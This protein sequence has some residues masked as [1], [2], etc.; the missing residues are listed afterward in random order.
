S[1][2]GSDAETLRGLGLAKLELGDFSSSLESLQRAVHVDPRDVLS[3][4]AMARL[5]NAM[6]SSGMGAAHPGF[7]ARE[8]SENCTKLDPHLADAYRQASIA[9]MRE[10]DFDRALQFIHNAVA[11][12]P[13]A[14]DYKLELAGLEL[15]QQDYASA[16]DLLQRLK[17]SRD[18]EVVKKA[19][20]FLS[21]ATTE[22]L[23]AAKN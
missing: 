22:Q 6:D 21:A 20:Y 7:S 2:N 13:R 17:N 15:K 11:L 5:L 3:R 23:Q 16:V 18:P 1:R 14:E 12:S 19:D 10:G 8:E 4:Y 9:M